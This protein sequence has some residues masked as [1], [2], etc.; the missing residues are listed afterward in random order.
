MKQQETSTT[1]LIQVSGRV[2][3][4]KGNSIPGAT[5]IIHGT[6]QGVATDLDGRYTLPLNPDDVL[7]VSFRGLQTGNRGG[8]RKT[9][10]NIALNPTAENI[11]EVTV[12]AFGTQ[13]KKVWY[14]RFLPFARWI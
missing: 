5:V 3:D 14:Q 6:T 8:K 10:V 7:R 11:E 4:E 9:K 1:K 2:T 13:K 12:V